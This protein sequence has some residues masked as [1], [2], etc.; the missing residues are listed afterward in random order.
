MLSI[1]K[2]GV[3]GRTYRHLNRYTQIL[4]ILFKYGFGELVDLLRIDQYIDIGF[5]MISR[6]R[7]D[8]IEKFSRSERIRM[9]LE[10][11]GPTYVKLGQVLSTRPD[12]IP[13]D[14]INEL[15]RLQDHVPPFDFPDA[16]RILEAELRAPIDTIFQSIDEQPIASASIAQVYRARLIDGDW[17]AVKVQRPGIQKMVEVDLEIMLHLAT[18]M[19]RHIEEFAFHRP[20]RIVEEFTRVLEKEIDF[21]LEAANMQR[22]SRNL[23]DDSTV[24]IPKVY[25]DKTTPAVLIMELIDGI[26]INDMERIEANGLDRKLLTVRGANVCLRQ[27]FEQGFFHADPHPGNIQALSGNVICLLDW[28]MVGSIDQRTRDDFITL[29]DAVALRQEHQAA[30][31]LLKLT[32]WDREP[33][34]REFERDIADFMSLHLYRPLK[35][36]RIG[37]LFQHILDLAFRHRLR[38]PPDIFLM[39]KALGTVEGVALQLNSE[40]DMVAHAAP[41]I[42]KIRFKK[43]SPERLAGDVLHL[44]ELMFRFLNQFPQDI[45]DI[46]RM[47]RQQD[48][49]INLRH[50]GLD[51]MRATHD[52]ISNRISFSVIIAGLIVGSA[53]IVISETPPM[54]YGISLIGII[55]FLAAALMGVWLLIAILRKGR[56]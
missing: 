10:E 29:V 49:V 34:V 12:L 14:L 4:T 21:T 6:K 18:L 53:L 56:L 47:T 13:S 37:R 30:K 39:L 31:S 50:E 38:I 32:D 44:T 19:E 22:V 27:I 55:G 25:L 8:R 1:R 43:L 40:F 5:R 7:E 36:I 33:D 45:L 26:K 23:L 52:Q 2:I 24:Y 42:Q 35:E 28:G 17:V 11:L 3:I 20:V 41:F 9:V 16:K 48:L 51:Q 54:I 15:A 46:T